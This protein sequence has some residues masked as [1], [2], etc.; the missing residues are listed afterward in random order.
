MVPSLRR[1]PIVALCLIRHTERVLT[2]D[3]TFAPRRKSLLVPLAAPSPQWLL[4]RLRPLSYSW[5]FL[6][7]QVSLSGAVCHSGNYSRVTCAAVWGGSAPVQLPLHQFHDSRQ[8]ALQA[9]VR[10]CRHLKLC[11]WRQHL[12]YWPAFGAFW[13]WG[14]TRSAAHPRLIESYYSRQ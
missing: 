10:A 4:E 6:H 12:V 3:S 14:S 11:G 8:I 2:S 9:L 5:Q 13:L 1:K 7:S